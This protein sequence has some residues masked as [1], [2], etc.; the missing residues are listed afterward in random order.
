LEQ[1]VDL[2]D[3][4][5]DRL[6]ELSQAGYRIEELETLYLQLVNQVEHCFELIDGKH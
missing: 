6:D 4:I 5:A 3:Q 1:E 2:C